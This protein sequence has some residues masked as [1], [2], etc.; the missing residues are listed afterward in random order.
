MKTLP[1]FFLICFLFFQTNSSI[2]AQLSKKFDSILIRNNPKYDLTYRI[3]DEYLKKVSLSKSHPKLAEI[4]GKHAL[5]D[6]GSG[7]LTLVSGVGVGNTKENVDLKFTSKIKCQDH[8]YNW[9]INLFVNGLMEKQR[10][11]YRT[12]SGGFSMDVDRYASVNWDIGAR[13][14]IIKDNIKIGDF[15]LIKRPKF[16]KL[17]NNNPLEFL[18]D[19]IGELDP[20][21]EVEES[22]DERTYAVYGQVHNQNFSIVASVKN[23]RFWLFQDEKLKAVLQLPHTVR[24]VEDKMTYALLDPGMTSLEMTYWLKLGLYNAYLASIVDRTEYNW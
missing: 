4:K 14:E 16:K 20:V 19:S 12:E 2:H 8:K 15:I 6:F 22:D 24:L 17:A 5:G 21:E 3:N 9:T 11:R 7:L 18:S 10:S 13:G 23:K 1:P